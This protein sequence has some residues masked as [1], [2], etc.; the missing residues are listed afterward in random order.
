MYDVYISPFL[1]LVP[2]LQFFLP[3]VEPAGQ[4]MIFGFFL[5]SVWIYSSEIQPFRDHMALL[6]YQVVRY[7]N[8]FVLI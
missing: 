4:W 1:E 8:L 5:L 2:I 6:I 7:E 3:A